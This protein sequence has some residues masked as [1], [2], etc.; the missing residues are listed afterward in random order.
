MQRILVQ[1]T[2][3]ELEIAGIEGVKRRCN[4]LRYCRD[5]PG[6]ERIEDTWG[7]DI[8]SR[9][10]EHAFGKAIGKKPTPIDLDKRKLGDVDGK[11]VRW[12]RHSNGHLIIHPWDEPNRNYVLV[13]GRDGAFVLRGYLAGRVGMRVGKRCDGDFW[14]KQER[15]LEIPLN[16]LVLSACTV[17]TDVA[18]GV[19]A[20]DDD[21]R[22][23]FP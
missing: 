13:T 17:I 4:G 9:G 15:L 10:S 20:A 19:S 3:D 16:K 18:A 8:N 7:S 5:K 21:W 2:P 14:V 1:L 11:E 22:H 6:A 12:T 23:A